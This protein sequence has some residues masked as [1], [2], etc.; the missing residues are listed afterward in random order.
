MVIC[1]KR[2]LHCIPARS[3]PGTFCSKPQTQWPL[4]RCSRPRFVG[5]LRR[6]RRRSRAESSAASP[7]LP[8][9]RRVVFCCRRL[10]VASLRSRTRSS[11]ASSSTQARPSPRPPSG[12][13][14]TTTRRRRNSPAWLS[15]SATAI[16]PHASAA[17]RSCTLRYTTLQLRALATP[18]GLTSPAPSATPLPLQVGYRNF[19]ASVLAKNQVGFARA[20]KE[21]GAA[22]Q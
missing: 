13:R 15:R 6:G 8:R 14:C 18:R 21:S 1:A 20:I 12:C 11:Q 10:R 7:A 9:P 22:A 17:H 16:L 2:G 19:F 5:H 3:F 4:R